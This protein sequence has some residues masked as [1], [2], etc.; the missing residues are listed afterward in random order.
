MYIVHIKKIKVNTAHRKLCGTRRHTKSGT[1][2]PR[3]SLIHLA[4][5]RIAPHDWSR[6]VI[7]QEAAT[8]M[9]VKWIKLDLHCT[10]VISTA[11]LMI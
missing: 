5:I 1:I 9:L 11:Q 7:S 3:S 4:Y 6:G 2:V 8:P 10:R